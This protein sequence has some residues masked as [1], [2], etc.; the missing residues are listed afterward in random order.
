MT[1]DTNF[2]YWL[3]HHDEEGMAV[4]GFVKDEC[5]GGI[6]L[7]LLSWQKK[8]QNS[9]GSYLSSGFIDVKRHHDQGNSYKSKHLIRAGIP[10]QRFSPLST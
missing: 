5:A 1:Q 9:F 4:V 8:K 7:L 6:P 2:L 10:F 3:H